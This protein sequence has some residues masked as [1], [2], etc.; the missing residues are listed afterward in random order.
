MQG[1]LARQCR[2]RWLYQA[3]P[4][5]LKEK[6]SQEE[7]FKLVELYQQFGSQW[8]KMSSLIEG[9]NDNQIKNRFNQNIK[10]R[11]MRGEFSDVAPLLVTMIQQSEME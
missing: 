6:W 4:N 7:D 9:R 8:K 11:V 1:R 10:K 2:E 3:N 5:I